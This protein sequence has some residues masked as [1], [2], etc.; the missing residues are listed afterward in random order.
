M[1]AST[2]QTGK[3]MTRSSYVER[4]L[5]MMGDPDTGK[6]KQLRSMFLD[7]RLGTAGKIPSA[8]NVRNS[9]PLG[10]ERRLYLRLTSP[11]EA[12][13]TM[14]EF[15]DT[16]AG[17]MQSGTGGWC[18]WNFAGALQVSQANNLPPGTEVI[19]K[20]IKRFAPERVRAVILSPDRSGIELEK[21]DLRQLIQDLRSLTGCEVMMVD[22]TSLD[23]NG[24]MYADFFDFT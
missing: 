4:A 23:A 14:K 7:W 5:F 22:A 9:Y 12:G 13:D 19:E 1:D 16:C 3:P 17:Q 2:V 21:S 8:N 10:N 18:R 20:F 11:H 24:L 6:S 15:L